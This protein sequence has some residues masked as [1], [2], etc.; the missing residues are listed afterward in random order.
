MTL[1]LGIN[2]SHASS[3]C[4]I[5]DN[6][7]LAAVAEERLNRIK[8][9]A[10][11]PRLAIESVLNHAGVTGE[12]LDCVAVGTLCERFDPEKAAD[13]EYR[14]FIK[15][16]GAFSR[17][18]PLDMLGSRPV[19]ALYRTAVG[20]FRSRETRKEY[21]PFWRSHGIEPSIL[22]FYDHHTCHAA[23]AC[24][25]RPWQEDTIVF[26]C[27]GLG[28]GLAA[29]VSMGRGTGLAREVEISSV[30]SIGSFYSR[31][32]R[33]L[34]LKPWEDEHKVM[35]LAGYVRDEDGEDLY[36]DFSGFFGLNG[37]GFENRLGLIGTSLMNFLT[38]RYGS[39]RFDH[40]AYAAQRL[41]EDLIVSWVE[42]NVKETG[43][44]RIALSGGLFQNIKVNG[45]LGALPEVDEMFVFPAA[46]DESVSLGASLLAHRDICKE[47]G[48]D[49]SWIPLKDLYFGPSFEKEIEPAFRKLDSRYRLLKPENINQVSAE[50]L[51]EG[52]IIARFRGRMEFGPRALGNRSIL[53]DPSRME[54]M[55]KVNRLVKLRDFWMPFAPTI[56]DS[57]ADRY[58]ENP[59][60]RTAHYM[61]VAFQTRPS[62]RQQIAAACHPFDGTCRPQ[63]LLKEFN[64]DY[65]DLLERF[66]NLRGIG[67]L[68]NTSLNLHR[69]P[70]AATPRDLV[71]ILD[72]SGLRFAAVGDYL[73]EK[74][75]SEEKIGETVESGVN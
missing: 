42:R 50:L 39:K 52:E 21:E 4:L 75:R 11:F 24:F 33:L 2:I 19:R 74:V 12:D 35:G 66:S 9:S 48:K 29:A 56:L 20:S 53:A 64:P 44:R 5:E 7:I 62:G 60:G 70:M 58:L 34:G 54:T 45:R 14:P 16:A 8:S 15:A 63:V 51:A 46:G 40:I 18:I 49:V 38:K 37:R 10:A 30:H 65:Y 26:T 13:G 71:N 6:R 28:D 1:I 47:T 55:H 57:A 73:I 72:G 3:A 61:T 59:A 69:M 31:I 23:T 68:L 27:D 25:L 32:T 17:I 67:A 41:T 36:K 22:R 43:I